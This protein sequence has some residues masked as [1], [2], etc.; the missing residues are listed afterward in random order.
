MHSHLK[1]FQDITTKESLTRTEFGYTGI[2]FNDLN[3]GIE[4]KSEFHKMGWLWVEIFENEFGHYFNVITLLCYHRT[5]YFFK[6]AQR[7]RYRFEIYLLF[8][9]YLE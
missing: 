9:C 8:F 3:A 1:S 5:I 7:L 2:F 6:I 4:L